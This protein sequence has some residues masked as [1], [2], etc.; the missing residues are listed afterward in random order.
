MQTERWALVHEGHLI[1]HVAHPLVE[2]L[3]IPAIK[4]RQE[5][6]CPRL[7]RDV[8][9]RRANLR[10]GNLLAF[11]LFDLNLFTSSPSAHPLVLYSRVSHL[12]FRRGISDLAACSRSH[13]VTR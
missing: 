10:K 13:F 2:H 11:E 3:L 9:P 6:A 7:H 8:G 5:E 1:E 4:V 12:R